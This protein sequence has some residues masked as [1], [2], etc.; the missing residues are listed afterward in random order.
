NPMFERHEAGDD[1]VNSVPLAAGAEQAASAPQESPLQE[2]ATPSVES[3]D[4]DQW[5]VRIPSEL[6]VDTAWEA[7][8]QTT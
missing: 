3:L 5:H 2:S 7:I 8:Y 6:P 4:D 1:F